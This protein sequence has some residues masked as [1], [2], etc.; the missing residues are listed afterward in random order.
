MLPVVDP[1]SNLSSLLSP[2]IGLYPYPLIYTQEP[3]REGGNPINSNYFHHNVHL[4]VCHIFACYTCYDQHHSV[5]TATAAA[6]LLLLLLLITFTFARCVLWLMTHGHIRQA[7]S[8]TVE[9]AAAVNE[10]ETADENE[11]YH[12]PFSYRDVVRTV[13]ILS[14]VL[15]SHLSLPP[16]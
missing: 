4:S 5:A 8:A 1:V 15:S 16:L 14:L 2:Q 10:E 9:G 3:W 11:C 12:S 6:V 7:T 13:F